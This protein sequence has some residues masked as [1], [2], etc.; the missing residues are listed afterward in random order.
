LVIRTLRDEDDITRYCQIQSEAFSPAT[1]A[2]TENLIRR[3]PDTCKADF[4]FVE[5]RKNN[6]MASTVCLIPWRCRIEGV[7]LSV[8]M[9]EMVATCPDYRRLGLVKRQMAYYHRWAGARGFDLCIIEGIPY[10]YRQ[11]GYSYA[12]DHRCYDQLLVEAIPTDLPA[13]QDLSITPAGPRNLPDLMNAYKAAMASI[14]FHIIRDKAYWQYLLTRA[15]YPV[16]VLKDSRSE[17]FLGY[18]V[19]VPIGD[20]ALRVIDASLPDSRCAQA[21]LRWLADQEKDTLQLGWPEDSPLVQAGREYG[22]EKTRGYQWL[23]RIPDLPAFLH[24]LGPVFEKRLALAGLGRLTRAFQINLFRCAYEMDFSEGSLQK[25][26]NLGFV[27]SSIGCDGGDVCI[28]RDAFV[29]LLLGYRDLTSLYDAWPD[30]VVKPE[31]LDLI[32]VL[33][34]RI[35]AHLSMPYGYWGPL[36]PTTYSALH[37]LSH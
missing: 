9:L 15:H 7:T 25:V 32:A 8:A 19:P 35:K 30:I 36:T 2:S 33:F 12:V 1:G 21:A 4:I 14:G 23:F 13:P 37:H 16:Q 34:P 27:D 11:Y 3:H 31:S 20:K 18:F 17:R 5:D 29:R 24:K 6:R 22:S 28:P 26:R 10:Y